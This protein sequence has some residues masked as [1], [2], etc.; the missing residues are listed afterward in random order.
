MITGDT[1]KLLDILDAALRP[2]AEILEA[3]LF[4]SMATGATHPHS[5]VDVAVFLADE[6][7]MGSAFGYASDL[8]AVLMAALSTNRVDVVVLNDAPPLL[9]H[10]VLRDGQRILSRDLRA[11]TTRE[12]CALSRYCDY[13]PQL[14]KIEAAHAA[15]IAAGHF[16]R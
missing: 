9:Y 4:G 14:A 12:G 10:R 16:G 11:T 13:V 5:D 8:A 2:R 6:R 7:P 1:P 3:Y 15:R